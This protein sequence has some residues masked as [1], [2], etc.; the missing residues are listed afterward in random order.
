MISSILLCYSQD[1]LGQTKETSS[2][3]IPHCDSRFPWMQMINISCIIWNDMSFH[4]HL[5]SE[6]IYPSLKSHRVYLYKHRL[7][8]QCWAM[9]SPA[10]S[11]CACMQSIIQFCCG[12][13]YRYICWCILYTIVLST[14]EHY[15]YIIIL[16]SYQ[17]H[18]IITIHYCMNPYISPIWWHHT[19]IRSLT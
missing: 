11:D 9:N 19:P 18:S 3:I 5:K 4:E 7:L 1:C 6:M 16:T 2:Y 12:Q 17:Y 13:G 14:V 10:Y 15:Q 8:T